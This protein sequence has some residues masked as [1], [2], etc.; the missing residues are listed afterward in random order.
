MFKTQR[1]QIFG[2]VLISRDVAHGIMTQVQIGQRFPQG[3]LSLALLPSDAQDLKVSDEIHTQIKVFQHLES[4]Q[5]HRYFMQAVVS[6][7]ESP[8]S[9]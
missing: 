8:Q 7:E 9:S 6:Q 5:S 1:F 3:A 4:G 2:Q